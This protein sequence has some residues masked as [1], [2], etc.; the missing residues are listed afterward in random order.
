MS[1]TRQMRNV[2]YILLHV[3]GQPDEAYWLPA[4]SPPSNLV[5]DQPLARTQQGALTE[6]QVDHDVVLA[7][8]LIDIAIRRREVGM[9]FSPGAGVNVVASVDDLVRHAAIISTRENC[10][11]MCIRLIGEH[12][13]YLAQNQI[14]I[15]ESSRS[16]A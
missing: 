3:L 7:K 4:R 16:K 6:R 11:N 8:V 14:L 5:S 15:P 9:G 12:S 13:Q 10:I 1:V 2:C